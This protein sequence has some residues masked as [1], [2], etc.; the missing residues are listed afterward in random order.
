MLL[1]FRA[2]FHWDD[3]YFSHELVKHESLAIYINLDGQNFSWNLNLACSQSKQQ[4]YQDFALIP[5][6]NANMYAQR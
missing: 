2:L 1:W 6:H 4:I 3:L 5:A